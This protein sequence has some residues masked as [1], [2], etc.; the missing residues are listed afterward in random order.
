[1]LS[2]NK[3][4]HHRWSSAPDLDPLIEAL[5]RQLP[6]RAIAS[7]LNRMGKIT[8]RKNGW[9]QSRVCSFR[10]QRGIDVYNVGERIA[11]VH[12]LKEA[13]EILDVRPMTV[14][15]MIRAGHHQLSNTARARLGSLSGQIST[16]QRYSITPNVACEARYHNQMLRASWIFNNIARCVLCRGIGAADQHNV[17]LAGE[18]GAGG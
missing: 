18:E 11:H 6:D 12:T 16:A 2:K 8:G 4:G 10:N 13:A 1:M 14:L 17:A 5:A 15:R 9:T 7:L 3:A